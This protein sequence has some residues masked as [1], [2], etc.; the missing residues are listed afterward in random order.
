MEK[1]N[2]VKKELP[3]RYAKFTELAAKTKVELERILKIIGEETDLGSKVLK[4]KIGILGLDTK[5]DKQ[6]RY[7][8]KEVYRMVEDGKIKNQKLKDIVSK[9]KALYKNVV[10]QKKQIKKLKQQMKKAVSPLKKTSA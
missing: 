10:Q 5:I 4:N 8:G 1:G 7:L 9:I 6:Y 2:A 3:K